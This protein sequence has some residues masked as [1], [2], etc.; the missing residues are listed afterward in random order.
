MLRNRRYDCTRIARCLLAAA[1]T[2]LTA[3][4]VVGASQSHA[5]STIWSSSALPA[6]A[7]VSDTRSTEVGVK[8]RSDVNGF[9]TAIRFYKGAANTGTHTANLWTASGT[10]L[11]RV[12]FSGETASGWQQVTLPT[13]VP[14]TANTVYVASYFAPVGRYAADQAYFASVGVDA[15]PLHALANAVSPNGVFLRG[16]TTHS[17]PAPRMPPTTGSTWYSSRSRRRP[18]HRP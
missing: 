18:H 13:P 5:Q 9:V 16:A 1:V 10:S 14:I 11:A 12:N 7:S 6:V 15:P 8:F 4:L 2:F 17:R 3:L